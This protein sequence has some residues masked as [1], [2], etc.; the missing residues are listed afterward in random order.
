MSV[1]GFDFFLKIK[2]LLFSIGDPCFKSLIQEGELQPL[3]RLR[4]G[5]S[6]VTVSP[7]RDVALL[8]HAGARGVQQQKDA[9][10]WRRVM[11]L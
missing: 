4:Y 7:V 10:L 6:F 3:G 1:L 5:L 8:R 9:R 2:S 11:A